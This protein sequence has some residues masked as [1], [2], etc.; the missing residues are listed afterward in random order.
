MSRYWTLIDRSPKATAAAV[1]RRA[2][3]G[4]M[5][6]VKPAPGWRRAGAEPALPR[7]RWRPKGGSHDRNPD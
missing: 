1:T 4:R 5:V 2:E 7:P 3:F 6:F